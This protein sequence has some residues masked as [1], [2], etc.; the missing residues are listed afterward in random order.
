MTKLKRR[1]AM[2]IA[3]GMVS[4]A[5]NVLSAACER[6]AAPFMLSTKRKGPGLVLR[7][8]AKGLIS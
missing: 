4:A 7:Y 6:Y 1:R 3:S 2:A 8:C 5:C